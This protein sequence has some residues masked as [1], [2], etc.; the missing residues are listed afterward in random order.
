MQGA[1]ARRGSGQPI[2]TQRVAGPLG[3]ESLSPRC[4]YART[5][6]RM[7][8]RMYV[9]MRMS[10]SGCRI[11]RSAA[12]RDAWQSVRSLA[13]G[14]TP[15]AV[16]ARL[17]ISTR[18]QA[19]RPASRPVERASS[20]PPPRSAGN[21]VSS[22]DRGRSTKQRPLPAPVPPRHLPQSSPRAG[23][24]ASTLQ[25]LG[26]LLAHPAAASDFAL[27]PDAPAR[28]IGPT[29]PRRP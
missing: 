14:G 2:A 10:A 19:S 24:H 25:R 22:C 28:K 9:C 11:R 27:R 18:R 5:Y 1:L 12:I 8:A 17:R 15:R 3:Q 16:A 21:G 7:C 13:P 23:S 20:G 4:V 6:A 29:P 26:Q